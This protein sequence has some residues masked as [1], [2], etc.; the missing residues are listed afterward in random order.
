MNE[1]L[2]AAERLLWERPLSRLTVGE[3]MTATSLGRSS[4]YVHFRDLHDLAGRLLA[5]LEAELW[6]PAQLW[7]DADGDPRG[8]LESAIR[9]VVAVWE[10]HGPV[11][12]AIVEAAM[13]DDHVHHLWRAELM[14]RFIEAVTAGIERESHLGRTRPLPAR[15]TATALLLL[16]E[17]Y[18]A[19]RLGTLPQG[20]A[21]DVAEALI[22]I[23]TRTLYS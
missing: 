3:L 5:R 12:R 19:D 13:V 6:E 8:S 1:I 15:E 18:L 10:R 2:D 22:A 4:F 14:E 17:R 7:T 21:D 11:L 23:W 20:E 16:N 9:G